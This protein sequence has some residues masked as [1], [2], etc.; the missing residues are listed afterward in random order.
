MINVLFLLLIVTAN[1]AVDVRL[2]YDSNVFLLSDSQIEDF[3]QGKPMGFKTYDDLI[4]RIGL[5]TKNLSL[6]EWRIKGRF[7]TNLY[8]QN[9]VKSYGVFDLKVLKYFG[10]LYRYGYMEYQFLPYYLIRP[11]RKS[12]GE[13]IFLSFTS[14]EIEGGFNLNNYR[15][16]FAWANEDYTKP[17]D[18]YDSKIYS[19]GLETKYKPQERLA[20]YLPRMSLT[21]GYKILRSRAPL[22]TPDISYNGLG[23]TLGF[24][25]LKKP[26][27][28]LSLAG[29]RRGFTTRIDSLHKGR[30]DLIGEVELS[31]SF[32]IG[33]KARLSFG[34]E[35][36]IRDTS[37][38]IEEISELKDY[39][40]DRISIGVR[41]E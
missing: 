32:P 23:L 38:E 4:A 7:T 27:F 11:I 29:E 22:D 10:R 16:F 17:W 20:V 1:T 15:V 30:R 41:Y 2:I 8:F 12:T 28:A 14:Q 19:F 35:Y 21:L 6:K 9:P 37:L 33:K 31:L 24:E 36:K 34:Y 39:N 25:F 40:R 18:F 26:A 3:I 13:N 5:S